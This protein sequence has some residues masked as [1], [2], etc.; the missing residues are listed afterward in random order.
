MMKQETYPAYDLPLFFCC[1]W[2][3]F[4]MIQHYIVI[5]EWHER[6]MVLIV[7]LVVKVI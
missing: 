6:S 5:N 3:Q 1:V 7:Q 2:R 4:Y